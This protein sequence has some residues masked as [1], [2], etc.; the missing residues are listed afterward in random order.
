MRLRRM[1]A[2]CPCLAIVPDRRDGY[3]PVGA[4]RDTRSGDHGRLSNPG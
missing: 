1:L 3:G 2:L 4:C